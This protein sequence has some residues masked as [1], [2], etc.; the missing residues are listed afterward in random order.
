MSP[1]PAWIFATVPEGGR[2]LNVFVDEHEV[3]ASV[4]EAP[5]VFE[6]LWWGKKL[7]GVKRH[8]IVDTLG[9]LLVVVVS[10]ASADDGTFA[11]EV[12]SR[13]TAEHR[14]RLELIWAD[15]K[16]HN[17][18]LNRWLVKSKAGYTI[19]GVLRSA[20]WNARIGRRQDWALY[21]LL[22]GELE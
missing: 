6:E 7:S 13:L 5:Q 4:A 10:A 12:L 9:L 17:H 11:P 20:H 16:Y 8:I 18:H 21:S 15:G 3:R 22:P 2:H 1:S 19:E 14:T